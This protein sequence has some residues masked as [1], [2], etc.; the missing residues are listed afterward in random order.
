MLRIWELEVF[1]YN[2]DFQYISCPE[3]LTNM[4][5]KCCRIRITVFEYKAQI[6]KI[7]LPY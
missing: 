7:I 4:I 2:L 3:N 6:D 5:N 1:K